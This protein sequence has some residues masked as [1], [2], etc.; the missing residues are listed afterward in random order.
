[1][2]RS[3]A[4]GRRFRTGTVVLLSMAGT[5]GAIALGMNFAVPERQLERHVVHRYGA[6]DP[7]FRREMSVMMGPAIVA[8]NQV[9]DLQNGVEIFPAMLTAVRGARSTISFETYIYWSGEIG[10]QMAEALAER[11]GAGVTV[12]VIIDWAGSVK[13]DAALLDRMQA[14]GVRVERYRPLRW[15]HLGR[16]NNRTHRK[17]LIVDGRLAFTGGV[18]IAD[19]W[20]GDGQDPDHW[21]ESHF[22]IEGPV[23][24]QF[25]AAFNDNW[26]KTT[27][28]VLNGPTQFPP[29]EAAGTQDAHLFISSPASGS[30]SMHL[31]YLMAIAAAERTI[32]V[33][34]SYFVPDALI[35]EA[36]LV[37]R[38]RGVRVRLLLP[39][40]HIDSDVV[41]LSSR[42][43]WGPLLQAGVE[44]YEYQPTMLHSKV[45][46]V[47]GEMVSV[48]STNLDI[49]SFRLND[50]A[51]LNVYDQAFAARMTTV[52][53]DD[54]TRAVR[55]TYELWRQRPW[56]EKL[57]ETVIQPIRS[58]L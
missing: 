44:I 36:F 10:Q 38:A 42:S 48:G 7:Q 51:S 35:D 12:S 29:L 43:R 27:G 39:G 16:L 53:E 50:E 23:V 14:A 55:Y 24:A 31:M 18:G 25:Q 33:T 22:R 49:R 34:A 37:A 57:V 32:D 58:Q 28:E 1:M 20:Q 19:H 41:R 9:T 54:L 46:I 5:A 11:A 45:F 40:P 52:F 30:D 4:S 13:M 3:P 56:T 2:A 26:I 6:G 8:G 47:D 17:L 15:Y 21:R